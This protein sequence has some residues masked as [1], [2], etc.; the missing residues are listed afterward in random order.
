M[1]VTTNALVI[2]HLKK[3]KTGRHAKTDFYFLRANPINAPRITVPGKVLTL[4][5][6]K[7][8]KFPTQSY[9]REKKYILK[10]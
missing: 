10:F 2:G 9:S 4:E 8:C 7:A 1:A 6:D 3:G 5:M